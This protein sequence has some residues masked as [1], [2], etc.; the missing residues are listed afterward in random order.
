METRVKS[1]K[2][3]TPPLSRLESA[4]DK[5]GEAKV[6]THVLSFSKKEPVLRKKMERRKKMGKEKGIV[7]GRR[8]GSLNLNFNK[9]SLPE[10][11]YAKRFD[12][13]LGKFD[14]R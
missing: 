7:I 1:I 6:K 4:G 12:Q 10:K 8:S 5:K 2:S 11:W 13:T 3:P 14:R 9:L